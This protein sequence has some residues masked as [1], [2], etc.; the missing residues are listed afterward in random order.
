[1]YYNYLYK[2][3]LHLSL[4][5]HLNNLNLFNLNNKRILLLRFPQLNIVINKNLGLNN[6]KL[7]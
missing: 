6:V 7:S 2:L 1:M 5:L 4:S 3:S